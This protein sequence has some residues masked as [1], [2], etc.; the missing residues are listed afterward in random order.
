MLVFQQQWRGNDRS[1]D[2]GGG[3]NSL[4]N[5]LGREREEE[6]QRHT[7]QLKPS[8]GIPNITA[9]E[10]EKKKNPTFWLLD[11]ATMMANAFWQRAGGLEVERKGSLQSLQKNIRK[12]FFSGKGISAKSESGNFFCNTGFFPLNRVRR[13][14]AYLTTSFTP[15]PPCNLRRK[16]GQKE[17]IKGKK[18]QIFDRG[19]SFLHRSS[20]RIRAFLPL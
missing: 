15:P 2:E 8:F 11:P 6:G 18:R 5:E 4:Q 14:W 17:L 19:F 20:I 16:R 7:T 1:K 9:C 12:I 10:F 13:L 3:K